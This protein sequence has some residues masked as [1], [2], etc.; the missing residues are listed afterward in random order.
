MAVPYTN[1]HVS[2]VG[3]AG[4]VWTVLPEWHKRN[5]QVTLQ[6]VIPEKLDSSRSPAPHR[7]VSPQ[8]KS[9][10]LISPGSR[11]FSVGRLSTLEASKGEDPT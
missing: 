8:S 11:N 3:R 9:Q 5:Y 1:V 4:G 6:Y 7:A 10:L 2:P